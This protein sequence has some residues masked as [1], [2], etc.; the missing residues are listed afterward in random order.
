M[1]KVNVYDPFT[2]EEKERWKQRCYGAIVT[3]LVVCIISIN[4]DCTGDYHTMRGIKHGTEGSSMPGAMRTLLH[5]V[6]KDRNITV[7]ALIKNAVAKDI[8]YDLEKKTK[9]K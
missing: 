8:G 9:N 4:A 3:L 7:G 1:T 6:A 2:C 5:Q